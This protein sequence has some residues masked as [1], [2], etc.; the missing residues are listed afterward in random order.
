MEY[1]ALTPQSTGP[2]RD[3]KPLS[4]LDQVTASLCFQEFGVSCLDL[5]VL[6]ATPPHLD[7]PQTSA[8]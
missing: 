1:M 5:P 8:L 2:G 3:N 4:G 6:P 7:L